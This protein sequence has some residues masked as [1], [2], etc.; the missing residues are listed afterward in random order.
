LRVKEF[1][2]FLGS[3]SPYD[4]LDPDDLERLAGAVEVELFAAG[5]T[6]VAD[7]GPRLAAFVRA[8]AD[9]ST[10]FYRQRRQ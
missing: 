4:R 5:R 8:R 6:I 2:D 3:Q 10:D 7:N 1:V 9:R